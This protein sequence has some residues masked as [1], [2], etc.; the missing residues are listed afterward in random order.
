MHWRGYSD[1]RHANSENLPNSG[2]SSRPPT[3]PGATAMFTQSC[4]PGLEGHACVAPQL[5][6]K[7]SQINLGPKLSVEVLNQSSL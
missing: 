5:E 7:P 2:C 1:Q 6:P 4:I 3:S